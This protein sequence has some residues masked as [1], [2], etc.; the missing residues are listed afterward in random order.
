[1]TSDN[2]KLRV[3]A[4]VAGAGLVFFANV[5]FNA[6]KEAREEELQAKGQLVT[7]PEEEAKEKARLEEQQ[8][9][10]AKAEQAKESMEEQKAIFYSSRMHSICSPDGV[11]Y[12]SR[13][14]AWDSRSH[15]LAPRI[16]RDGKPVLCDFRKNSLNGS[17]QQLESTLA[18]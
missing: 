1:M 15:A 4:F 10:A 6:G 2:K 16:G 18:K 5:I 13:Y 3:I 7:S 8:K 9:A 11:M 14:G 12:W 17:S